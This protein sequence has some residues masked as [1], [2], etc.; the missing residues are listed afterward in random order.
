MGDIINILY[1]DDEINNINSFKAIFRRYSNFNLY[2]TTT[3]IKAKEIIKKNNIH[4]ILSDQRM[5]NTTG[6]DFF[7][8][9]K[10]NYPEPVRILITAYSDINIIID[11]INKG[12][13]F[14][15]IKKPWDEN[16]LKITL[17]N[18]YEHYNLKKNNIYLLN[19]LE[20]KTE[21][22]EKTESEIKKTE[23]L[24]RILA[25]NIPNFA[26]IIFDKDFNCLL[27][28]GSALDKT[29]F[30][31]VEGKN[32]KDLLPNDIVND[33]LPFYK[34]IL[35]YGTPI[36]AEHKHKNSWFESQFIP[37]ENDNME[38]ERGMIVIQETTDIKNMSLKLEK[39]LTEL[40]KINSYLDNFVYAASHDL[41]A[42][43]ANLKALI[44]LY[45]LPNTNKDEILFRIKKGIN[46][47]DDT[48]NSLVEII[49]IQKNDTHDYKEVCFKNI[50]DKAILNLEKYIKTIKP[51]I[52]V[53]FNVKKIYYINVYLRSIMYNLLNNSMKYSSDKR[54]C[55]ITIKTE[56]VDNYVLLKI[57]DNGIGIDL[58]NINKEKLFEPFNRFT[59]KAKGRGIGLHLVKNIVEKNGG[60][61][62]VVSE[63]DKKTIFYIYLKEY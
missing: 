5:P 13:I 1:V 8:W 19:S 56:R 60:Y 26:V 62:N 33:V 14:R 22:L 17:I 35:K 18:A 48:L 57:E 24:Y 51:K 32:L 16:D 53:S 30:E 10:K 4:I 59:N 12:E 39:N 28:D 31:K 36:K 11:A 9:L 38:I 21:K 47:I 7:E 46:I 37:I 6:V 55:K 50:Y 3:V 52:K 25:R 58:N 49:D 44:N 40:T 29:G 63:L 54:K 20:N 23:S 42:P 45:D 15:Y 2:L 43:V 34:K 41:K 61:I 27:A